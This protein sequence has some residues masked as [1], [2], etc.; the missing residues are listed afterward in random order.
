V[1][2]RSSFFLQLPTFFGREKYLA[3]YISRDIVGLWPRNF[4]FKFGVG[5][6]SR[7]FG[8][9]E[10]CTIATKKCRPNAIGR[11]YIIFHPLILILIIIIFY[12]IFSFVPPKQKSQHSQQTNKKTMSA[13]AETSVLLRRMTPKGA[14]SWSRALPSLEV[15]FSFNCYAAT[16]LQYCLGKLRT[17]GRKRKKTDS[18][19]V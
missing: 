14:R 17:L 11:E 18:L 9:V 3:I 7:T 19:S 12:I 10:T 1:R 8:C 5:S 13:L 15:S 6:T 16:L 4:E 2:T